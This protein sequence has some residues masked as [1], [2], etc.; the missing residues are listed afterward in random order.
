V[1]YP[2]AIRPLNWK[3]IKSEGACHSFPEDCN[4]SYLFDTPENI[5]RG[6]GT[7]KLASDL[8]IIGFI[9][10]NSED[11]ANNPEF[12]QVSLLEEAFGVMLK[13]YNS[14]DTYPQDVL[15]FADMSLPRSGTSVFP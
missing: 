7:L 12:G 14:R 8:L 2:T 5:A 3:G 1:L 15:D 9:E 6:G 11:L 4:P 13:K 10:H